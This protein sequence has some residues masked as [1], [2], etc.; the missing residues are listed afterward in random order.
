VNLRTLK[1]L[2]KGAAR[3]LVQLGDTREQFPAEAGG[4][5]H[6]SFIGDRKHWSR[7]RCRPD[8][9]GR[10][11]WNMPR[12]HEIVYT[13]RSGG[14]M[15]MRPPSHPRKGTVMVGAMS[16]GEQPE[17]DEQCAWSALDGMVRWHFIDIGKMMRDDCPPGEAL[18]RDLS[19]PSRILAAA[20]EMA[21]ERTGTR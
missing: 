15:V 6:Q 13:T 14:R 7:S 10:N 5:F 2:S 20:R 16:G 3:L 12:G 1:K 18:T 19:T 11:G 9:E 21:Q 17:W 4:N 8:Y